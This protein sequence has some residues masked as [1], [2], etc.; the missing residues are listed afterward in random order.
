[1]LELLVVL[2][3]AKLYARIDIFIMKEIIASTYNYFGHALSKF[4]LHW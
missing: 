1:M 2:F 4:N 3:V